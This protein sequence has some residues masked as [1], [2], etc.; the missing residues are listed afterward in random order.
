MRFKLGRVN[1][2]RQWQIYDYLNKV[3]DSCK[4]Y[5]QLLTVEGWMYNIKDFE[6]ME[7]MRK[8]IDHI[9]Y[10]EDEIMDRKVNREV[11]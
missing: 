1:K 2:A 10:K 4:T 11:Q 9:H 6:D 8:I 3:I 7:L 5:Q